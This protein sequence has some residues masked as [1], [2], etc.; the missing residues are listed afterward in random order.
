MKP[1]IRYLREAIRGKHIVV[2]MAR[3][4][5]MTIGHEK[6]INKIKEYAEKNSA[7]HMLFV[8]H[9]HDDKSNPLPPDKKMKHLK[10]AFP[11]TNMTMTSPKKNIMDHIDDLHSK[12]YSHVSMIA[13]EDRVKTYK[14]MFSRYN[15][16]KKFK[17][18]KVV[19]AGKRNDSSKDPTER[20]SASKMRGFAKKGDYDSFKANTPT[21]IRNNESHS[22]E[23]FND[24]KKHNV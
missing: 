18:M 11:D 24:L 3:M 19:T 6:A 14:N 2:A 21:N 4:N 8:S 15:K 20:I 16:D 17:S 7:D 12:G 1:F 9:S 10:R 22:K 13:G 23:L 5:P